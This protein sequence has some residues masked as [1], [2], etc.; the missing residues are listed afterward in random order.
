[1]KTDE[2]V[3]SGST[4]INISDEIYGDLQW[5]GVIGFRGEGSMLIGKP[6][7]EVGLFGGLGI[8]DG[9]VGYLFGLDYHRY[10]WTKNGT[11][12]KIGGQ[13]EIDII[14]QN[15]EWQPNGYALQ[16]CPSI[17]TITSP[18]KKL[19]GGFHGLYSLGRL[20]AIRWD[21]DEEE[22][23][24]SQITYGF[25]AMAGVEFVFRKSSIQ[26]E[27]DA[28]FINGKSHVDKTFDNDYMTRDFSTI[29]VSGSAGLN[30]FKP[31]KRH[32]TNDGPYPKPITQLKQNVP[33]KITFDP[34]TGKEIV[35]DSGKGEF[36]P[37]TG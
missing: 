22:I 30:F 35:E 31:E 29:L 3:Y 17:S 26:F 28:S 23:S 16:L 19:Y 10:R 32:A 36:D 5:P 34:I 24:Y 12:L 1:M 2:K 21:W 4:T 8:F 18:Q 37:L 9:G 7:G 27:I 15:N 20:T 13:S 33:Q 6:W 11:G 14:P 25:G